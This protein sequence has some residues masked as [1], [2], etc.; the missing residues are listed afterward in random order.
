MKILLW[1]TLAILL[2]SCSAPPSAKLYPIRE[3]SRWGYID[4]T[5]TVVISPRF[6]AASN[7]S[8]G[9]AAVRSGGRY[10]YINSRGNFVIP[11]RFDYALPFSKGMAK[12]YVHG[13][14]FFI[15]QR[16]NKLF[17]HH[18]KDIGEFNSYDCAVVV[19]KSGK[20]GV[21]NRKGRLVADTAFAEIGE[22]VDGTA[23]VTGP[24][25]EPYGETN[26]I[27]IIDTSG[28]WVVPYGAYREIRRLDNGYILA[29]VP[30][31]ADWAVEREW[32]LNTQGK[33]LLALPYGGE[34]LACYR[35]FVVVGLQ[36]PE[37]PGKPYWR[38]EQQYTVAI[39]YAGKAVG[40]TSW[41]NIVPFSHTRMFVQ[42]HHR[43]EWVLTDTRGNKI[44]EQ[45]YYRVFTGPT[46]NTS[47]PDVLFRDGL[48]FVQ[49]SKGYGAIDTMGRF[50]IAPRA[51]G[52]DIRTLTRRGDIVFLHQ[53]GSDRYHHYT[54]TGFW[55]I[56]TGA[57]VKPVFDMLDM[58]NFGN[59]LAAVLV[60]G[61][62]GYANSNGNIVWMESPRTHKV[63]SVNI[64]YMTSGLSESRFWLEIDSEI[65]E[66]WYTTTRVQRITH[67]LPGGKHLQMIL[68]PS[69]KI[70]VAGKMR[71]MPLYIANASSDTAFFNMQ[72]GRLDVRMQAV[73]KHGKWKDIEYLGN[74]DC[75]LIYYT[76]GLK[77]GRYIQFP[78]PQYAG[79]IRTRLR[80]K[81]M[82]KK[83]SGREHK[84][85]VLY[86][87][88][89]EGYVNPGQFWRHRQF[90]PLGNIW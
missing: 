50:V 2:Y 12:V 36:K 59:G 11:A 55:N 43:N 82:Y 84:E 70:L 77:S 42:K 76:D 13:K 17:R 51:F 5:G 61:K 64:D 39:D 33:W 37:I 41:S 56:R 87:N 57:V 30:A 60:D 90:Y 65:G 7:F 66:D 83:H 22:F 8:E 35:D 68:D 75:G 73:T 46:R 28:R 21:I 48:A 31:G 72:D 4:T 44:T 15:D 81:L 79:E 45:V 26:E 3:G 24:N 54:Q 14:P 74:S 27:G 23:I 58:V 32:I 47:A 67:S 52:F 49:N 10:G 20:F 38:M 53:G 1:A 85:H 34:L 69:K 62:R 29:R 9:L 25:H 19:A 16:G 63:E 40:D 80:A 78:V 71:A 88:E 86:S 89:I 6:Y 18:Y